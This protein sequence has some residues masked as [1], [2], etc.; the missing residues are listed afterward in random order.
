MREHEVRSIV[1]TIALLAFSAAGLLAQTAG[2]GSITGTVSDPAGAVVPDATVVV[3][4]TGTDADRTVMT[5]GAGLYSATFL[6]PG[7][8]EMTNEDRFRED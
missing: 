8:Y 3:H 6:Q 2:S 1:G 4:N 5:N 7:S